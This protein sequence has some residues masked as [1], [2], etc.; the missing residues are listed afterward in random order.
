MAEENIKKIFYNKIFVFQGIAGK[1]P[2]GMEIS[3]KLIKHVWPKGNWKIKRRVLL[4]L[5]LLVSAK[6]PKLFKKFYYIKCWKF[7]F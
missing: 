6:V 2:S 5:A 4:A 3:K 7:R 1:A